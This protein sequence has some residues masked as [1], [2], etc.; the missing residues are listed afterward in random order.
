MKSKITIIALI[1][2]NC[3]FAS[4]NEQEISEN[5]D[6][7]YYPCAEMWKSDVQNLMWDHCAT[8]EE[9]SLIADRSFDSCLEDMYGTEEYWDWE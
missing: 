3:T 1:L 4:T 2:S 5:I 9:A 7:E 8:Y 6:I